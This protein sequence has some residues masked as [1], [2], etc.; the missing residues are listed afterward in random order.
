MRRFIFLLFPVVAAFRALFFPTDVFSQTTLDGSIQGIVVDSTTGEPIVGA[1]VFL[2]GTTL[3]AATGLDG[4]FSIRSLPPGRYTV[5]ASFVSYSKVRI[6]NVIVAAGQATRLRVLLQEE[7]IQTNEVVVEGRSLMSYE[8]ALLAQQKKASAIT[9]GIS[10][11]QIKRSPDATAGDALRRVA[12]VTLADNKFLYVRGT[13][14]RYSRA[15]LNNAAVSSTEP[16]K[17]AFAFDLLPVNLLES[18][19]IAKSFTPDVPGDFSGGLL[20]LNTVDFPEDLIVT[21]GA[22]IGYVRGT[23]FKTIQR[24]T[25]GTLDFLG[26]DDGTRSLPPGLP[27]NLNDRLYP[28]EQLLVWARQFP[29]T[30]APLRSRAGTNNS[31]SL[32]VGDGTRLLG[33]DFGFVAA[34]SYRN[35]FENAGTIR[36]EYESGGE[37]RYSFSGSQSTSSVLWGGLLNLSYAATR[38]DKF[39]IRNS[40]TRSSSDEVAQF[41]GFQYSDAGTEQVQTAIR[42]V[43][44]SVFSTQISGEHRDLAGTSMQLSW[45]ASGSLATRDEPDYRRVIFA[46]PMGSSEPFAAVL[47]FQANLKNGGRYF[48]QLEDRSLGAGTDLISPLAGGTL[49]LGGQFEGKARA[50]QSRLIGIIVNGRNNGYTDPT[51]YTLPITDIFNPENFRFNGFSIDEYQNG[52]NNY[53]AE[54]YITA[55]Y[56]MVDVPLPFLTDRLRLIAGARFERATQRVK[57]FDV[58]GRVPLSFELSTPDLLPSLN[59]IYA[60]GAGS[61]LRLAY[62]ETVNRPELREL[63]PFAYFDFNTQ[64]SLRGNEHLTR[65]R[66][67]NYDI[68]YEVYPKPGEVLS[69]SLFAKNLT[70]A[71]EQVVITGSALGSERTFAN[72]DQARI[73]GIEFEARAGLGSL[74]EALSPFTIRGNLSLIQSS[75]DVK[76]TESTIAREGRPLQG[77]SPY[78]V[79]LGLLYLE[80]ASAISVN[81]LYNTYGK[82]VVEV[83]TAYE[84]DVVEEPREVI[85]LSIGIPFRAGYELKLQWKDILEQPRVYRQGDRIAR[86]DT[87]PGSISV[88][89]S[90]TL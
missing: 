60:L 61:N 38:S 75:V 26:I 36:K 49:K 18:T 73:Y 78:V 7:V 76:R 30:W 28:S 16:E 70:D 29:N 71:I 15:L 63:A 89:L 40:Y 54:E 22:T 50:F 5:M 69:V 51:L 53:N 47:G 25:K 80:P 20:R 72:A 48:S 74:L 27:A 37:P 79:N 13:S 23:T 57:S 33:Q 66:I 42:F 62:S 52:T 11:E 90:V 41:S 82:R 35:S 46:R 68:R 34:L 19:V 83:A 64:T 8:G 77:Q 55:A 32:S 67:R 84:E 24:S 85:D 87:K 12:G 9:D 10:A 39:T 2:Q 21:L 4:S 1:N 43:S 44:R 65:A 14:E 58:S 86:S 6:E 56:A 88:G 81:L 45:R 59:I 17:K 31:L 3:G